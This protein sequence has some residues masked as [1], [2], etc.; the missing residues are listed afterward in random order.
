[1]EVEEESEV[2]ARDEMGEGEEVMAGEDSWVKNRVEIKMRYVQ[3]KGQGKGQD[4]GED[5]GYYDDC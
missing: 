5:K 3:D 1:M 2:G 4:K